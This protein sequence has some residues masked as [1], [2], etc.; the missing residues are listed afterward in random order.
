M[1]QWSD[2]KKK[3]DIPMFPSYIFAHVEEAERHELLQDPGVLN[4]V[5]WLGKPAI[6]RDDEIEA[7]RQIADEG[8][9]IAVSSLQVE[10]G[11][12]VE[13][14][15]GPFKGMKGKIDQINKSNI[16]LYIQQ[17]DCQVQFKYSKRFI[18]GESF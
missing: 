17:L 3:V 18:T 1:R 6:V 2:R 11:Q 4:Y 5:Y 16:V 8:E 9:D 10:K 15:H 13:I 7:I 14:G 12:L